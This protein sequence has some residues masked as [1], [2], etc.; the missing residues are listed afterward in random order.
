MVISQCLLGVAELTCTHRHNIPADLV[1]L[2]ETDASFSVDQILSVQL[3]P[4]EGY[5]VR[6]KTQTGMGFWIL[7]W[8]V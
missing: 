2:L 5:F 6:S 1:I 7:A 3:F 4:D 8:R